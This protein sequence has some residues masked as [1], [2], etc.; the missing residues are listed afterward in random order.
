MRKIKILS[1]LAFA[2]FAAVSFNACKDDDGGDDNNSDGVMFTEGD[3]QYKMSLGELKDNDSELTFTQTYEYI[4]PFDL[5]EEIAYTFKYNADSL[6]QNDSAAQS[7]KQNYPITDAYMVI[8]CGSEENAQ[9]VRDS[10]LGGDD[11]NYTITVDGSK[12]TCTFKNVEGMTYAAVEA[13]Y[14]QYADKISSQRKKNDAAKAKE[15][16]EAKK[17][18][19]ENN[20]PT[21]YNFD[22]D[23][24]G[25]IVSTDSTIGFTLVKDGVAAVYSFTFNK[26]T[27]MITNGTVICVCK[28]SDV[29]KAYAKEHMKDKNAN[30]QLLYKSIN[31]DGCNVT[32]VYSDSAIIGLTKDA[33][34][35]AQK[36][37]K[38]PDVE[39]VLGSA[40]NNNEEENNEE[41]NGNQQEENNNSQ[42]TENGQNGQSENNDTPVP[43]IVPEENS[44]IK[45]GENEN[46]NEDP[47]PHEPIVDNGEGESVAKSIVGRWE[48]TSARMIGEGISISVTAEE[49]GV[50][51][52][53]F[54]SD[55]N[56]SNEWITEEGEK[57]ADLGVYSINDDVIKFVWD[58]DEEDLY[59]FS[60]SGDTLILYEYCFYVP[61]TDTIYE[62]YD[63][64]PEN[65]ESVRAER[66]FIYK[67]I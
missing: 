38:C 58:D 6:P 32:F 54:A 3:V 26:N 24:V 67:R 2:A 30:G 60:L 13:L 20:R 56:F 63:S 1:L 27:N 62:T 64:V 37:G 7:G 15:D 9:I 36:N 12:L 17:Q 43:Q 25:A 29:A 28:N 65:V 47:L 40:G 44:N 55:G 50:D 31:L 42:N 22:R 4:K 14:N 57:E 21:N 11:A 66:Q 45:P 51:Y 23:S 53:D 41:N 35:L 34:I 33:I 10:L 18:E 59:G 52:L 49:L 61:E 5:K 48:V 46:N 39:S 8:E 16:A 19:A